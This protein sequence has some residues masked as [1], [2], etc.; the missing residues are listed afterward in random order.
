MR[1]ARATLESVADPRCPAGRADRAVYYG[2]SA[3]IVTWIEHELAGAYVDSV[4]VESVGQAMAIVTAS[5][6]ESPTIFIFEADALASDDLGHLR[7][8][9]EHA[10]QGRL[11]AIGTLPTD[12]CATLAIECV[13]YQP[14]GHGALRKALARVT[15]AVALAK[16]LR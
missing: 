15:K 13:R 6:E 3:D 8:A 14:A 9:R 12:M 11:L 1:C 5:L 7:A 2:S 16:L 10:W 4:R